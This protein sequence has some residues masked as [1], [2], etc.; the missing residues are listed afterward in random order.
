MNFVKFLVRKK[1]KT[2]FAILKVEKERINWI[3]TLAF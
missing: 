1:T 3:K 2:G